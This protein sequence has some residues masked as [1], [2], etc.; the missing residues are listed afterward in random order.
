MN[1]PNHKESLSEIVC[2]VF[3]QTAFLFPEKVDFEEGISYDDF[4]LISA[5]L[6]FTGD[7]AGDVSLI[8][9]L[10]LCRELAANLLGE[11]MTE[12]TDRDKYIDAA[13][14]MLN[15]ITGQLLTELFGQ[16]A[17][18]SLGSPQ[19]NDLVKEEF[20]ANMEQGDYTCCMV[21]DYPIIATM[22]VRETI[23]E[24]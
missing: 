17:L 3:E 12:G 11:D 4:E 23:H 1:S 16:K 7:L 15:I 19:V 10:D 2:K 20:F 22:R 9:P 6:S 14:E 21:D 13:K 24:H 8:L 5:N 18:F